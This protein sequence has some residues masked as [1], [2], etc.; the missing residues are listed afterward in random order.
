MV[1]QP[2][3]GSEMFMEMSGDVTGNGSGS[4]CGGTLSL[5]TEISAH[6]IGVLMGDDSSQDV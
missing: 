3:L 1:R 2:S 6:I 4:L 5:A